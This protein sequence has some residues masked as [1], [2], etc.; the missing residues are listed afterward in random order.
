MRNRLPVDQRYR[1]RPP[2][3]YLGQ[4]EGFDAGRQDTPGPDR[5]PVSQFLRRGHLQH[6]DL[7]G[8]G[9]CAENG[10]FHQLADRLASGAVSADGYPGAGVAPFFQPRPGS[11]LDLALGMAGYGVFLHVG[12]SVGCAWLGRLHARGADRAVLHGHC[13]DWS[14]LRHG[15]VS[16]GLS[17]GAGWIHPGNGG[18]GR[19]SLPDHPKRYFRR[20]PVPARI[21]GGDQFLLLPYHLPHAARNRQPAI[22]ERNAGR[23]SARGTRQGA[24]RRPCQDAFSGGGESRSA[25][26][27]PCPE[28]AGLDACRFGAAR[29]RTLRRGARPGQPSEIGCQQLQWAA[30][31]FARYLPARC[32]HRHGRERG[33]AAARPLW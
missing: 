14:R 15:A 13:P 18:A 27:D 3:E 1:R 22:G 16:V 21:A 26:T 8:G 9:L 28:P 30:Q 24:D 20:L 5:T 7:D 31:R 17:A 19:P 2:G 11:P 12:P 23:A 32:G 10:R 33:G 6:R 25:P 29:R 4:L